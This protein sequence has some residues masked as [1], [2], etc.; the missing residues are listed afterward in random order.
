V[1]G[2]FAT[3]RD[4]MRD[5]NLHGDA[6]LEQYAVTDTGRGLTDFDDA[7][8][9]PAVLDLVR[10]ATSLVLSCRERHWD[11]SIGRVVNEFFRGYHAALADPTL[12]APAP[13]VVARFRAGFHPDPAR[14]FTWLASVN[15]PVTAEKQAAIRA[16][17]EPYVDAR[18]TEQPALGRDYFRIQSLGRSRIGIGSARVPKYLVRLRGRTDAP[19]DDDVLELKQISDLSGVACLSRSAA[20]QPTRVIVVQ[21]RIAY[22]PYRLVG[23]AVLDGSYFWVHAWAQSYREVSARDLESQDELAEIAFDSG[24][25]LGLGHPKF[26]ATPF[27][28]ELRESELRFLDAHR[29]EL[30]QF[31]Q[32]MADDVVAAWTRFRAATRAPAPAR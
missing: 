3:N 28:R 27:D 5:V 6:H 17:L 8:S 2:R 29:Q 22:D 18:L 26:I 25:Q 24:V 9:G 30:A 31:S 19:E 4:A 1:C 32:R 7:A 23:Y 13:R 21:A 16:A 15:E 11:S 12:N 14:F 20:L 10:F